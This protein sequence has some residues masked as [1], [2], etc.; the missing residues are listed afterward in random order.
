MSAKRTISAQ[1]VLRPASAAAGSEPIT[2]AN[3]A[4]HAPAP[5]GVAAVRAQFSAHGIHTHPLVANSLAISGELADFERLFGV[6]IEPQA[7]GS[8]L[9]RTVHG[10]GYELPLSNLPRELAEH[11]LAVTFTGPPDFGPSSF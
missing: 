3:V 1:V 6:A 4:A 7:D 11:L 5:E 9:V 8:V 10:D 2:A